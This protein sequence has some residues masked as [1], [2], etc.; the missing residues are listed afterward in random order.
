M[1]KS[2]F[3]ELENPFSLL[4]SR[5]TTEPRRQYIFQ[6]SFHLKI[7]L[8]QSKTPQL[9]LF[10]SIISDGNNFITGKL[11]FIMPLYKISEKKRKNTYLRFTI[12]TISS[13]IRLISNIT[14]NTP[15]NSTTGDF[16]SKSKPC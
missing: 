2:N 13:A 8:F 14:S 11:S 10:S 15:T 9:T 1:G 7:L 4:G 5:S 12:I 3:P 6:N 16:A